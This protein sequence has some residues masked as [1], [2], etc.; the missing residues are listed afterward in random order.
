MT[1]TA[2]EPVPVQRPGPGQLH[3]DFFPLPEGFSEEPQP[4][5][6]KQVAELRALFGTARG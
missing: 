5:T 2:A 3:D 6:A 4:L 1:T